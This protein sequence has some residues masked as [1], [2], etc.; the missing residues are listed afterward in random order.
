MTLPSQS[1][2]TRKETSLLSSTF[3]QDLL[4]L[5]LASYFLWPSLSQG[6]DSGS[7]RRGAWVAQSCDLGG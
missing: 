3:F 4:K 1:C 6:S 7:D 5:E 2:R